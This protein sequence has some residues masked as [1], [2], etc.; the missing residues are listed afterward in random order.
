MKVT[1]AQG[2]IEIRLTGFAAGGGVIE[3]ADNGIGM[4]EEELAHALVPFEQTG[5]GRSQ[6]GGTG[7]GLSIV[8]RLD[9][10]HGGKFSISSAPG[11]GTTVRISFPPAPKAE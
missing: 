7:L 9:E 6:H 3:V 1:A 10:M 5:A 8:L 4:S 2:E 11:K